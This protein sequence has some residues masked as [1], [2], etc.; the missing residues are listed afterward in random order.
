MPNATTDKRSKRI[1]L[2][3]FTALMTAMTTVLTIVSVPYPTGAGYY[4]FGD[5]PI[6]MSA[7]LL[8]PIPTLVTGALGAMLG[9][10]FLGYTMY[11]PFT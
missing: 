11:A 8:G 6:F 2:I 10:V 9:D 5:I 7:C 4:N 3:V 1:R